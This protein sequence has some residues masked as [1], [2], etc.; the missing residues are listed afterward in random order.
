MYFNI[1]PTPTP[2]R[3]SSSGRYP[4]TPP[5]CAPV[6]LNTSTS[7][8][9]KHGEHTRR[10]SASALLSK[11][12]SGRQSPTQR[13][14]TTSPTNYSSQ[15]VSRG[16]KCGS[17]GHPPMDEKGWSDKDV[18]VDASYWREHRSSYISFPAFEKYY[19]DYG[20]VQGENREGIQT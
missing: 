10:D 9:T 1:P 15:E 5:T 4:L 2:R 14:P 17:G 19:G 3:L 18:G 16:G 11:M 6:S 7:S 8:V 12:A 13:S 20:A